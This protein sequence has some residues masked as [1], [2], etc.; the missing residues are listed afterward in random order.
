MSEISTAKE[1]MTLASEARSERLMLMRARLARGGGACLRRRRALRDLL[2]RRLEKREQ[3][4]LAAVA[5]PR[6][7]PRQRQHRPPALLTLVRDEPLGH[8][9]EPARQIERLVQRLL[10]ERGI[11]EQRPEPP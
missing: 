9:H 3:R 7:Q 5:L 11:F 2:A 4:G 6:D 8:E 10:H 1:L